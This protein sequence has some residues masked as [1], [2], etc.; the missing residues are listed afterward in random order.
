[1]SRV[2]AAEFAITEE[3]ASRA[4]VAKF[5]GR[6]IFFG[7]LLL[8]VVTAI[9]YGTNEPWL[10]AAF[11]CGVFSL[12]AI[13]FIHS[14]ASGEL[15]VH[16]DRNILLSMLA[17]CALAFIQTLNIRSGSFDPAI[18][19]LGPWNSISADPFQTR[20]FTLQLLAL[21]TVLALFYRYVNSG[22]RVRVL[23]HTIILVA[24]ASAIFGIV[25]QTVQQ[26]PGFVLPLTKP[27]QGY[28]QFINK[29]HFAYL[30]EMA[31]GLGIGM[32][33]ASGPT[34]ERVLFYIAILV[35]IW[36]GLVLSNSRGGILAMLAQAVVAVWLVTS[37]VV[38]NKGKEWRLTT[39]AR[40]T[41]GRIALVLP[42]VAVIGLGTVWVGGDD[43]VSNLGSLSSEMNHETSEATRN[44][45]WRASWK[46]FL[47]HPMLGVGFGG[48]WVAVT[49]HH[50]ASG[51]QTP[52]EAHN[53]YLELLA[54]GG[55]I[56][57][58]IGIWFAV[59]VI[60][61]TRAN[62]ASDSSF[63][64]AVSFAA[65]LGI[66]GVAVHSMVDFGLHMMIN[67]LI[68]IALVMLATKKMDSEPQ[69]S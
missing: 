41:M 37:G 38:R 54:S 62:L 17:M 40:T 66:T 56:G 19:A 34:R 1:M 63:Q 2:L 51:K 39:L 16:G 59:S 64:R 36:T 68:L 60:R 8:I 29:N 53:D 69:E 31:F 11:I 47:A 33:L 48:Y 61:R 3:R 23:I 49:A 12:C 67:A 58:A 65:V 26:E 5:L 9:P 20:F 10:K 45:I 21:T 25:R 42:L 52:Q 22:R 43:L 35:P 30:M 14:I 50:E 32:A 18:D 46:T 6:L 57:V 28:A 27:N 24:A 44:E 15:G 55:V 13:A 7:L 4:R